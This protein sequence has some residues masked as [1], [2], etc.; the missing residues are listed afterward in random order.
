MNAKTTKTTITGQLC[1]VNEI[2][3]DFEL[4]KKNSTY[5]SYLGIR[6]ETSQLFLQYNNGTCFMF[7][8][9]PPEKLEAAT[10]AES[11]GKF[12]HSDLK[13]KF[14]TEELAHNCVVVAPPVEEDDFDGFD[15]EDEDDVPFDYLANI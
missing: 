7:N 1:L 9:V 8:A 4:A 5:V 13:G 6:R 3:K 2:L 14:E 12:F 15:D 11:I 10:V